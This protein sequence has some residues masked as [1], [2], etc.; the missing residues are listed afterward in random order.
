MKDEETREVFAG[1][2]KE[3]GNACGGKVLTMKF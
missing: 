2:V 1:D 3:S